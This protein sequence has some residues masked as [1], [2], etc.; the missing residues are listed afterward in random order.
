MVVFNGDIAGFFKS[1]RGVRQGDPI[2][3]SLFIIAEE[4]LSRSLKEAQAQGQ[5]D[6]FQG[7]RR[8]PTVSHLL[9]ADDTLIFT[10]AS[11]VSIKHLMKLLRTYEN[12][13]GQ[14]ININKS[15]FLLHPKFNAHIAARISRLTG[16]T[17]HSFPIKYL[18]Y[19]LVIGR[20]KKVH[21]VGLIHTIQ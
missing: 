2:A 7:P 4:S 6:R 12:G 18:G 10:K 17:R 16:F 1:S 14:L 20:R 9:F 5:I 11:I 8:A 13:S 21:F 19:P 3:P 15:G